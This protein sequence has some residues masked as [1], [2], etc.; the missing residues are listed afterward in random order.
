[1]TITPVSRPAAAALAAFTLLASVFLPA[2]PCAA[3]AENTDATDTLL[4][5]PETFTALGP[6]MSTDDHIQSGNIAGVAF[7]GFRITRPGDYRIWTRSRDYPNRQPGARR[8]LLKIDERPLARESGAHGHGGWYWENVGTVTLDTGIHILEIDDTARFF[9]RLEAILITST[10]LDPNTR[11]RPHLDRFRQNIV[12][13]ARVIAPDASLAGIA[14]PRPDARP[15]AELRNEDIA[16][17]FHPARAPDGSLRLWREIFFRPTTTTTNPGSPA[18]SSPSPTPAL[19]AGIEPL[20]L[21]SHPAA[22]TPVS[23]SAYFPAWNSGAMTE[24]DIAGR[25]LR[26]PSD[27]RDP[28][29]AGKNTP[30]YPVSLKTIN[31]ST[32]EIVYRANP[33]P[34]TP[35]IPPVAVATA[36]WTLPPT[37]HTLRIETTF[38]APDDAWYSLAFAPGPAIHRE[39]L[40]AVQLPPLFQYQ[41]I[42]AEPALLLNTFT[43]HPLS[44]IE[45]AAPAGPVT[46]GVIADPAALAR[47]WPTRTNATHGFT[48]AGPG[49]EPRP[50]IFSPILGGDGSRLSRGQT[51][52]ASWHIISTPGPW[53]DAMRES[54]TSVYRLTDYRE[55]LTASLA[56]QSLAIIDLINDERAS[57]WDPRFKGPANIESPAT[58]SHAAPLAY[59]SAA[60]LTRDPALYKTRALPA[61]E[62][63]LSRP[64]A[65]F[66]LTHE[67][68]TYVA[69]GD[70]QINFRNT[71]YG[72][73]VWQGID[74]LLAHLNPWL[75]TYVS[76]TDGHPLRP[77]NNTRG[78]EPEWSGLL[79]LHRQS[80]SPA[81]LAR[82]REAADA[83]LL[84]LQ[85]SDTTTPVG[86]QPF[87]NV[88]F[89]LW[90]WDLLDL[91][92]L[93]RESR[94]LDAARQSAWQTVAGQWVTPPPPPSPDA[95]TVLFPAGR[96]SGSYYVWFLGDTRFRLGFPPLPP[97]S[98]AG[99][100]DRAT[101]VTLPLPSKTVPA[102]IVSPVGLGL[103]QPITYLDAAYQMSNIQLS[104]WAANLLRLSAATGDDYW[105]VFARNSIIGRGASYPGYYLSDFMALMHD[106]DYPKKGPDL[107]SFYWH[108][109]PV[110]LAMTLDYL[111]TDIETRARGAIRFPYVKQQ[112]YVWFSNRIHGGQPGRVLDD[113]SCWPW[114]DR[115]S[116]SV[117]TPKVDHLGARGRDKFHL[118]LLN[119]A[120]GPATA[121]VS[122]DAAR[123][124]IIP[125]TTPRLRAGADSAGTPLAAGADGRYTIPFERGGWAVL[126]FDARPEDVWP[127]LPPLEAR[128]VRIAP[129]DTAW[130]EGRAFRIRSPYGADS[131]YVALSG[132]PD[133][134]KVTLLPDD[135]SVAPAQVS[136]YPYE[137]SQTDIPLTRDIRFRLRLERPGQPATET[138]PLSLPGT[139][140]PL[141]RGN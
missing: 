6:W 13:P 11:P 46:T 80:P 82:V 75:R 39:T 31:T 37:G 107:T 116:F 118:I 18:P 93:T 108:H 95:T 8:F 141:T 73:A 86:L 30:L 120:R 53:T 114:L 125:G 77:I 33:T 122:I 64:G 29:T 136:R 34:A 67:G 123:T 126:S 104:S 140:S 54:D 131:L 132:R 44:L 69:P 137:L 16:I 124:G 84:R 1:M 23:F 35:A 133:G 7:A 90:W 52:R 81:L 89:Y 94:Y 62:F 79:A 96:H 20:L 57:G 105:R 138:P 112:G 110:H 9:G 100:P 45:F 48:L 28:F 71:F 139:L 88:S 85:K 51:L 22:K 40:T 14:P 134:G 102:W 32:I 92:E 17:R 70:A 24:W 42:P 25:R 87:Y 130:G 58:V 65:H 113:D 127:A 15:L 50:W 103:E 12:Q 101:P 10:T 41:R 106:P 3:A 55:P 63:L 38:T 61:L 68:N 83:W 43:P 91:Y 74:A 2:A 135:G 49:G 76:T 115:R 121:R 78:Q 47:A 26:R 5:E 36:R 4:I 60:L 56:G 129:S 128:P 72:S 97:P 21:L 19:A 119:Q 27:T 59:F 99:I 111:F 66:A 98:G 117:D 109:V